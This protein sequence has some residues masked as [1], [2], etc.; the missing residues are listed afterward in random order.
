MNNRPDIISVHEL[1]AGKPYVFVKDLARAIEFFRE[2][3]D[4]QHPNL[5]DEERHFVHM[6]YNDVVRAIYHDLFEFVDP[7]DATDENGAL[8]IPGEYIIARLAPDD[9]TK[10]EYFD[11]YQDKVPQVGNKYGYSLRF[12]FR[13]IAKRHAAR[14]GNGWSVIDMNNKTGNPDVLRVIFRNID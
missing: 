14:L 6:G 3:M 1:P 7:A 5:T 2:S 10:V 13:S 9:E 8:E 4:Y 12:T 11:G